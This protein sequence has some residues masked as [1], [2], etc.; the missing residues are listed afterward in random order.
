MAL[1]KWLSY[2]PA[3]DSAVV[4]QF[5][6][7]VDTAINQKVR[8][9]AWLLSKERLP[10]LGEAVPTCRSLL[11]HYD[12]LQWDYAEVVAFLKEWV[13]QAQHHPPP[14]SR[15]VLIPTLYGD[16]FGPDLEFVARHHGLTPGEVI[17]LH[18]GADYLVFMLGFTPGFPYLGGMCSTIATP[19]LETPRAEVPAGSVGIAGQQTG[20]YPIASPGGWRIIGRTGLE[21]FDPQREPPTLL[22]PG[23]RVRFVPITEGGT[24]G[25][26]SE[27]LSPDC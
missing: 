6:A 23:D 4:V 11:V 10:G 16:V 2:L 7:R 27:C 26:R 8:T 25:W 19:R 1:G 3:G 18:S 20:I 5:G 12:P 15:L 14:E 13:Q 24:H 9:L 17:R 21:L 22:S